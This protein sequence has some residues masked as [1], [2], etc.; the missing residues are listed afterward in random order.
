MFLRGK[1]GGY[2]GQARM[3]Y[4]CY[5]CG[6]FMGRPTVIWP[7]FGGGPRLTIHAYHVKPFVDRRVKLDMKWGELLDAVKE[8]R[9]LEAQR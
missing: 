7:P 1:G 4:R 2:G 8:L 9:V 6:Q 5:V 3:K